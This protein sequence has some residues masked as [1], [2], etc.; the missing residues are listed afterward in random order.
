[1]FSRRMVII[2]GVIVLIGVNI[3][4]LFITSR[5]RSS[6][7][8]LNQF[9]VPLVAPF[10]KVVTRTIHFAKD[11]WTHYFFLVSVAKEND[12]LKKKLQKAIGKNQELDEIALSNSRLRN[13]LEF[14]QTATSKILVAEVVGK[15]PSPWYQTIII[16]K[17]NAEGVKKWQPV[18]I[19]ESI[20][21]HVMDVST[22]YAKVLLIVDR[23]SA[24]DATVQ[25][26]R[27]R[28]IIKG[29]AKGRFF[30]NYVLRKDDVRVGDKVVSSGFD[31]VFPK[32]LP[33]GSVSGVIRRNSGIFQEV[34][35]SPHVD[36]EKLEEVTVLLNLQRHDF[37]N[38][39]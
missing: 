30:F 37:V 5:N 11:V 10:Q 9:A 36:F 4:A 24:V 32:G 21:G 16:D 8:G 22:H 13:L 2:V 3:I 34:Y 31:G 38:K 17:G 26:T 33:I 1:M 25:R 28:G 27:T 14:K 7:Y 39:E 23:N 18:V 6:S 15:D 12:H 20:V 19:P 29:E 35:V